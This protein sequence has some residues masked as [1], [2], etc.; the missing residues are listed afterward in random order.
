MR[1]PLT[2]NYRCPSMKLSALFFLL[3]LTGFLVA[4][5]PIY[6]VA[7]DY[8]QNFELAKIST[9]DWL[10]I[11]EEANINNLDAVR[12]QKA[13]NTELQAKGLMLTT[14]SPDFLIAADVVTKEKQRIIKWGYPYYDSYRIYGG[15]WTLDYYQYEE[16]TFI[17]DFLEPVTKKLIWRG[18]A[19]V[20]LDY[21]NTPEKRDKL[22]KEAMH[23][24]L[25]N[26]PPPSE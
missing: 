17:L 22:M 24:I 14:G 3:M 13:V 26:Y 9:Y 19:K 20:A 25:Q 2:L 7:Y 8:D 18:A 5:S 11:P 21:A 12:I 16:G 6:N 10:P 15:S 1:F 23:K 4:C